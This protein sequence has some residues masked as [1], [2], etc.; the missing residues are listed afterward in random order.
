MVWQLGE[1][2]EFV[3]LVVSFRVPIPYVCG[4]ECTVL[5]AAQDAD[6]NP[7]TRRASASM[8]VCPRLYSD[9]PSEVCSFQWDGPAS[10][11]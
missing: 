7:Q 1:S 6:H 11:A 5:S 8:N 2:Y 3:E 4:G 10:A 9:P